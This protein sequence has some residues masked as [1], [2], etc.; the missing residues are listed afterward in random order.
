[1][2]TF[3]VTCHERDT[4]SVGALG[5]IKSV[6]LTLFWVSP[7]KCITAVVFQ[8][9]TR[10]CRLYIYHL[11]QLHKADGV[12]PI[13]KEGRSG[14]EKFNTSSKTTTLAGKLG[15]ESRPF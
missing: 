10:C 15:F 4:S 2:A 14:S 11:S 5:K 6:N 12:I 3:L 13:Y 1:M 8:T 7:L 9:P